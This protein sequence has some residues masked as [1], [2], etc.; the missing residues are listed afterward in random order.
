MADP[1]SGDN[2]PNITGDNPD[3]FPPPGTLQNDASAQTLGDVFGNPDATADL[4]EFEDFFV[5]DDSGA[6]YKVFDLVESYAYQSGLIQ[7]PLA[8]DDDSGPT[9]VITR[10][11]AP[12]SQKLVNCKAEREGAKPVAPKLFS[13]DENL[14]LLRCQHTKP[15]PHPLQNGRGYVWRIELSAIYAMIVPKKPEIDGMTG[16]KTPIV[17]DDASTLGYGPENFVD[18]LLEQ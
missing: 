13:T 16:S 3:P 12:T 2:L 7:S 9:C 8:T 4:D 10:V 15:V 11:H 6:P 17:T 1:I 5:N 14:V 18:G